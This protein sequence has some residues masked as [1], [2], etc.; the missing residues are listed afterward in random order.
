M[1]IT[2]AI[3]LNPQAYLA[4]SDSIA[5]LVDTML[6]KEL[7]SSDHIV[8]DFGNVKGM[9][10]SYAM[11]FASTMFSIYGSMAKERVKF[12][13]CNELCKEEI[14]VAWQSYKLD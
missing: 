7:G 2:I 9:T 14:G 8:F 11:A 4:S 6:P 3:S 1:I 10:T 12:K 5:Y 13:N